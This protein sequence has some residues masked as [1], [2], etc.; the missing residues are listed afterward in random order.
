[1]ESTFARTLIPA[2]PVIG[3]GKPIF[4]N[5]RT[6]S[7]QKAG[8]I[9]EHIDDRSY[10]RLFSTRPM[11]KLLSSEVLPRAKGLIDDRA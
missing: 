11:L 9:S 8:F 6:R 1:M 10:E 5:E 4:Y 2:Q 7:C 3:E